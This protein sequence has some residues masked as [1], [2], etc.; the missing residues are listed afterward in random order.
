MQA[1]SSSGVLLTI[2]W[3]LAVMAMAVIPGAMFISF[4]SAKRI[5]PIYRVLLIL[6]WAMPNYITALIW[7]GMF[8]R[9]FGAVSAL[10][11]SSPKHATVVDADG[12]LLADR[13]RRTLLVSTPETTHGEVTDVGD[14]EEGR[15]RETGIPRPEHT[16]GE[17]S[18]ERPCDESE[19]HEQHTDLGRRSGH[20]VPPERV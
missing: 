5:R 11:K 14:E 3:R 10:L 12:A 1:V 16:P 19:P 13:G 7:K 18:P 9:Q 17:P 6:P 20:P 2:N 4:V 8:H 15:R